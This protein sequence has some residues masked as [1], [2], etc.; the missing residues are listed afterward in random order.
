MESVCAC[1]RTV[2]SNPTLSATK[3]SSRPPVTRHTNRALADVLRA[4]EMERSMV[5]LTFCLKRKAGLTLEQFQTYWFEKHAPLVRKHAA[6]LRIKR[7][8]QT[9]SL[10]HEFNTALRAS[11]NTPEGFDGVAELWWDSIEDFV[12]YART[13]AGQEAAMELLQDEAQFI[14]HENSPL[15]ISTQKV[16]V[17][18]PEPQ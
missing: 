7:Y 2:G 15:W 4:S 3:F 5:K 18:T 14:D 12:A 10:D 8:V 9:H 6:T 17:G 13:D 1:K 11:R 16:V